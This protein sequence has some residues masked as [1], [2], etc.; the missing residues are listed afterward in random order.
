MRAHYYKSIK[1]KVFLA[2]FVLILITGIT[3]FYAF[4]QVNKLN[5][6]VLKE[7]FKMLQEEVNNLKSTSYEFILK[8]RNNVDFFKTNHSASLEKYRNAYQS[9]NQTLGKTQQSLHSSGAG[10]NEELAQLSWEVN[11]YNTL[12]GQMQS[13]MY[14]RGYAQYGI[15]GEF[16]KSFTE[17]SQFNFGTDNEALLRLKLFVKEY[18]LTG[19]PKIVGRAAS[20]TYQFSRILEKHISD[21][22]VDQVLKALAN[23]ENGLR[24]LVTIDT[25]IG[26]YTGQGLQKALFDKMAVIDKEAA[27]HRTQQKITDAYNDIQ[28][29]IFISLF[30]ILLST[31]LLAS[32]IAAV[33]YGGIIRPIH[34]IQEVVRQMGEGDIPEIPAFQTT[35]VDE[36]AQS[37]RKL[38]KGLQ[39]TTAFAQHI[40]R[41][42]FAAS[43]TT[44]SDKDI[45]GNAL[46]A[47]RDNLHKVARQEEER[48]WATESYTAFV[49]ILRS[50]IDSLEELGQKL[51][52][53]VVKYLKVNQ[54]GLFILNDDAAEDVH[55]ELVACYAWGKRKFVQKRIAPG[56]GLTGQTWIEGEKIYL[57]EIPADYVRIT[58][59]LGESTPTA[60]LILPLRFNN[61]IYG[62]LEL[63]SFAP[64]EPH[65]IALLEKVAESV[66]S[67]VATIKI[68]QQTKV[69]LQQSQ[70]QSDRMHAQEEMMR[71]NMEEI[72]ATAEE[73]FRKEQE[74]LARIAQ[75]EAQLA[76]HVVK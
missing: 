41:G 63:A 43:F 7:D 51:L 5:E 69:L 20:E 36:M 21:E 10:Q 72:Q 29:R 59:G 35:E 31:V 34:R 37:V 22:E 24:K 48:K 15:I 50:H 70:E 54:G 4:L 16:D 38:A 75:L 53:A 28:R 9:F 1:A 46:L 19:D 56:E 61:K 3:E 68:N 55:L 30:V 47:M 67:S 42:N 66:A 65:Q 73:S 11:E 17:I 71:Q 13:K 26:I 39:D 25:T 6:G 52:A 40:G 18:Q 2:F 12:F 27:L 8:D 33:L 23:Y 45:L 74:Y 62:I 44:L 58:S 64:I 76:G 14:E 49:D 57:T 60:I 32:V